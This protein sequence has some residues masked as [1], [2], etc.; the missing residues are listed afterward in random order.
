MGKR[1]LATSSAKN[2]IAYRISDRYGIPAIESRWTSPDRDR[3]RPAS[4]INNVVSV[5][6]ATPSVIHALDASSGKRGIQAGKTPPG[7]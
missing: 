6:T 1:W 4:V 3:P 2:V 7:S 5:M